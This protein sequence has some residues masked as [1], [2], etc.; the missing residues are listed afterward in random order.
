MI[1]AMAIFIIVI[2]IVVLDRFLKMGVLGWKMKM[3]FLTERV[4]DNGKEMKK[5][6]ENEIRKAVW[7]SC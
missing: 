7:E 4:C 3:F 2:D 6:E 1:A 5:T